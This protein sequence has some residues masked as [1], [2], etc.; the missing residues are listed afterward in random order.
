MSQ[1][2]ACRPNLVGPVDITGNRDQW[3]TTTGGQALENNFQPSTG[4]VSAGNPIGPW[5]RPAPGQIGNAG[6]NT[7]RGPSFFQTDLS[8]AKDVRLTERVAVQFRTDAFNVFNKVNLANPIAAVDATNG[9]E[10]NALAI[11]AIQRT[12]Q[13]SLR[14]SF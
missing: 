2:R 4:D 6:R 9:G 3:F 8:V 1:S 5:Q 10:I 13:F 12:I 7:L 11:G 14:V